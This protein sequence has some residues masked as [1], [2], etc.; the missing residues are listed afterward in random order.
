MNRIARSPKP[1][2]LN[3]RCPSIGVLHRE[4]KAEVEWA[5][6]TE[7]PHW[8]ACLILERRNSSYGRHLTQSWTYHSH[9]GSLLSL[10]GATL[11]MSVL[12]WS[13]QDECG[14]YNSS[15]VLQGLGRPNALQKAS[16]QVSLDV[17]ALFRLPQAIGLSGQPS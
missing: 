10:S 1:L 16:Q 14:L 7:T 12:F 11:C 5:G 15:F 2:A 9:A 3:I 17:C 4:L 8:W 6:V 13:L